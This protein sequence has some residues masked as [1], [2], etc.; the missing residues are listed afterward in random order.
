MRSFGSSGACSVRSRK[1]CKTERRGFG[2]KRGEGPQERHLLRAHARDAR[3]R[4]QPDHHR[5][6]SDACDRGRPRRHRP[7]LVGGYQYPFGIGRNHPDRGQARRHLRQARFLRL[8]A[9]RFHSGFG[10]GQDGAGVLVAGR[11]AGGARARD[12][13]HNPLIADHHRRHQKRPRA[14]Q[15]HGL[16]RRDVRGGFGRAR[17]HAGDRPDARDALPPRRGLLRWERRAGGS[18]S[19]FAVRAR[20]R[21]WRSCTPG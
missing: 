19:S 14:G 7:L 12:G 15:V 18:S 9:R 13:D 6:A 11:G 3:R 2:R 8:R 21:R 5:L 10:F 20:R 1:R 17:Q 4:R 16:P